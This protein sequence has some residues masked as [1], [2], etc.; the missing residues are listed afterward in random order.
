MTD[1]FVIRDYVPG[2]LELIRSVHPDW[3]GVLPRW[4]DHFMPATA[5]AWTLWRGS[6][7][8]GC[9]GLVLI[10]HQTWEMWSSPGPS[11]PKRAWPM[12]LGHARR[13]IEL[14]APDTVLVVTRASHAGEALV[15]EKLGFV[16]SRKTNVRD[17]WIME[18]HDG[19]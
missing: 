6:C 15:A 2:D 16:R 7:A 11:L 1:A 17:Y 13:L 3:T 10:G 19:C 18:G 5:K 12:V 8:L 14:V 4:R 9:G